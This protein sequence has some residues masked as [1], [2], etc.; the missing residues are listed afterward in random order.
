M[1]EIQFSRLRVGMTPEQVLKVKGKPDAIDSGDDRPDHGRS[2]LL[3]ICANDHNENLAYIYFVERWA[4]RYPLRD[5]YVIVFFSAQGKLMR[6]FSNVAGIAP[7]LSPRS[8]VTWAWV[9]WGYKGR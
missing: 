9:A 2:A 3:G 8:S 7:L 4:R 5:R 1:V 6:I